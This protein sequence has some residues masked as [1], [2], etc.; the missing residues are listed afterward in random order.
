MP[1]MLVMEVGVDSLNTVG[2]R[3]AS[4][5]KIWILLEKVL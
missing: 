5:R 1:L 2:G 4:Q 3:L